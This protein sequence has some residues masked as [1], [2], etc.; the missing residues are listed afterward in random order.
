MVPLEDSDSLAGKI[1]D[2][3]EKKLFTGDAARKSVAGIFDLETIGKQVEEI[4]QKTPNR[5]NINIITLKLK[6]LG[7]LIKIKYLL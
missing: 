5:K 4:L 3:L 7:F 2:V 6:I 1:I